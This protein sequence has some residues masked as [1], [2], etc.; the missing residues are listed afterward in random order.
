MDIVRMEKKLSG[1]KYST[2]AS[3]LEDMRLIR[4]NAYAYNNGES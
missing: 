1:D 2:I 4:D 3:V